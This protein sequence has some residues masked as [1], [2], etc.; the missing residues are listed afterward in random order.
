MYETMHLLC[1]DRTY[2]DVSYCMYESHAVAV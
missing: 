1:L 2:T